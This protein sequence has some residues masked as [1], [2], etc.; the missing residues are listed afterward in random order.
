M[1][2]PMF[3][4]FCLLS[5]GICLWYPRSYTE[6]THFPQGGSYSVR[7]TGTVSFYEEKKNSFSILLTDCQIS[8]ETQLYHCDCLLVS[9]A[10]DPQV[11]AGNRL[12]LSGSLSSFLSAR[13][14]GNM[15]WR[16]YYQAQHISYRVYATSLQVVDSHVSW[17]KDRLLTLRDHWLTLLD[18]MELTW[19]RLSLPLFSSI[20]ASSVLKA[21][22][23]A[24]QSQ[25]SETV[26]GLYETAGILPI[27]SI[28][29]LHVSLL[30]GGILWFCKQIRLPL[31]LRSLLASLLMLL[32]WQLCG[33][34]ISAGRAAILFLCLNLAPVIHRS[35][36]PL[37]ALS[38]A[39]ILFLLDSPPL[40]FQSGF[41][42]SFGAMLGIYLIEP[43]LRP[44]CPQTRSD[45]NPGL[46]LSCRRYLS[47]ALSFAFSL[48]LALFPLTLYLFFRYPL[49]T[50]PANLLVL[51]L[52]APM[53]L[54]GILGLFVSEVSIP[55]GAWFALPCRGILWFYEQ[56]CRI[57]SLLPG[58]SLLLGRPAAIRIGIY[59]VLLIAFVLIRKYLHTP[60]KHSAAVSGSPGHDVF[61][62]GI[63]L[64]LLL[65]L[66]PSLLL[67]L[68]SQKLQVAFVDVGQG[69]CALIRSPSGTNILIDGGS[70][71][72]AQVT[73]DR[74]IPFLESQEIGGLDY[75]FLSHT[76]EDHVNAVVG[77]LEAGYSIG[78]MILPRLNDGLSS[79][80]SYMSI[81]K[82]AERYQIPLL[83]FSAGDLWQEETLSLLC[84]GPQA[85]SSPAGSSYTS[86]NA[87]SMVLMLEYQNL[88]IL[89]TGDCGSEGE[90]A[91][92]REL[93]DRNLTCDVL[94]AGHHGS[95][96]STGDALLHQLQPSLCIISCGIQ[97]T[98]GHPHAE[99]T[100]RLESAGIPYYTTADWG[101]VVLTVQNGN[102]RLETMLTP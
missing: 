24:N 25:L 78:T 33:G 16:L 9:T 51:P 74:L 1:K 66:L 29:G 46:W 35:Y 42:L 21:L 92:V 93:T 6:D 49:Y 81:R 67:P 19:Q 56:I 86:L 70:S 89:F 10:S 68:P 50:I 31:W 26:Y 77:W 79:Q 15:D 37:S 80:S 58:A 4:L 99:M 8:Y 28:S 44:L 73:E 96:T 3:L 55:L 85:A 45:A 2:R 43:S 94:K 60:E 100:A 17:L 38:L 57:I 27:L 62:K 32:Y 101:A 22:L 30:G 14:P 12:S 40:L 69:D 5:L 13:N 64:L 23:L 84:L 76:D 54:S 97:N 59:Y 52:T 20:D 75:V 65:S 48:Q 82:I 98:Y 90:T 18:Q 91:L 71:D 41:L 7:V 47:N 72:L 34:K 63:S 88:R 102:I 83:F 39:G 53:L 87:A 36:D 95:R 61:L 11:R